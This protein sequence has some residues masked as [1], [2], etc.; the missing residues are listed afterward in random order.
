[1]Q[2]SERVQALEPRNLAT[3]RAQVNRDRPS[4]IRFARAAGFRSSSLDRSKEEQKETQSAQTLAY[5]T[6]LQAPRG[7]V[8]GMVRGGMVPP[9]MGHLWANYTIKPRSRDICPGEG[10]TS[11]KSIDHP[12]PTVTLQIDTA[13]ALLTA[14]KA[15]VDGQ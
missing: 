14:L 15:A 1:M 4:Q 11:I 3:K 10:T 6:S 7:G 8:S 2:S 9:G 5:D 13:V 12:A